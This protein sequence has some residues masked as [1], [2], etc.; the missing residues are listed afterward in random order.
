MELS[1]GHTYALAFSHPGLMTA[2]VQDHPGFP[3]QVADRVAQASGADVQVTS[4][5]AVFDP[6]GNA[7]RYVVGVQVRSMAAYAP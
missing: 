1:P 4:H 7:T 6:E 2:Y 3:Q 5:G